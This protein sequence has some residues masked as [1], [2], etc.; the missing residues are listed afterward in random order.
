MKILP[1]I[2][3][4]FS[5]MLVCCAQHLSAVVSDTSGP[6]E[7]IASTTQQLLLLIEQ[8]DGYFDEDP[9]RYYRELNTIVDPL[10]DFKSFTR[11]VM[12]DYG[13][14]A[15]YKSLNKEQRAQYK[16]DYH[17]FVGRFQEGLINTYG[18]GLLAFNGQKIVV[19]PA[20]D[21]ALKKIAARQSVDVLQKIEGAEKTYT[22]TYKMRPNK[23]GVWLL[24]NVSIE[25]INVGQLY[26]NQ[27]ASAMN[28][29]KGNFS[30]VID[31]WVVDAKDIEKE[32]DKKAAQKPGA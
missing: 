28:K 31:T 30:A 13:T 4:V 19:E 22:V 7:R 16:K 6:H 9:D 21:E 12:G 2:K 18:K 27:F 1:T 3:I 29:H 24:R 25:S 10:V 5:L 8:A 32:R 17:R 14:K 26:R 20:D 15:Y 11:S 23:K